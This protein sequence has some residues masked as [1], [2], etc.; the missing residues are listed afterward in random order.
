MFGLNDLVNFV[1]ASG[2][3]KIDILAHQVLTHV[4]NFYPEV[5][6]F[7]KN[8]DKFGWVKYLQ[9]TFNLPN[10][11]KFSPATILHY[12]VYHIFST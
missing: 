6:S 5:E 2:D 12:T 7:T 4:Q 8:G 10:S 1:S 9:M 11:P 3:R